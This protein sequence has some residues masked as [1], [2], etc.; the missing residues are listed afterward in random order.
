MPFI[1]N[2]EFREKNFLTIFQN[3][4]EFSIVLQYVDWCQVKNNARVIVLQKVELR[5]RDTRWQP[6]NLEKLHASRYT[7]VSGT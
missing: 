4:I 7:A 6:T 1:Y 2:Q 5:N 3:S